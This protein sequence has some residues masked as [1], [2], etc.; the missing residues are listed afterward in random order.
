MDDRQGPAQEWGVIEY[1]QKQTPAR[2][3]VPIH[4]NGA[5]W[6]P[7]LYFSWRFADVAVWTG[8]NDG[9]VRKGV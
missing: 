3:L 2:L 9:D 4:R 8:L 6:Q 7:S 5:P 1:L